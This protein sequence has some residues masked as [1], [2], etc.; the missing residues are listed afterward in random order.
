MK[1]VIQINCWSCMHSDVCRYRDAIQNLK[2]SI[3]I[4][5]EML[6]IDILELITIKC[7]RYHTT[8]NYISNDL[9]MRSNTNVI[10]TP[11]PPTNVIRTPYPPMRNMEI[12]YTT[13]H[14][15]KEDGNE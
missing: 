10:R 5:E 9:T 14:T 1:D 13:A 12:V 4:D 6:D 8:N 2:N 3:V 7:R 15:T 11:Y